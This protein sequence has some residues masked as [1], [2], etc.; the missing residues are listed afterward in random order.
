MGFEPSTLGYQSYTLP[1]EL[2]SY[3]YIVYTRKRFGQMCLRCT[4]TKHNIRRIPKIFIEDQ[5]SVIYANW[6]GQGQVNL[7]GQYKPI[8][9]IVHDSYKSH[10]CD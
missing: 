2:I 3:R 8:F 4:F 6:E 7:S 9:N 5:R 1:I 10:N